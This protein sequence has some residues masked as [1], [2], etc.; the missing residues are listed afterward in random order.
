[1]KLT[2]KQLTQAIAK[3]ARK[4]GFYARTVRAVSALRYAAIA[5]F[6][7]ERKTS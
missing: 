1:M 2:K 5:A 7:L 3:Y 6:K 4:H